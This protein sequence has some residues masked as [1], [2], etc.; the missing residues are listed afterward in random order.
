MKNPQVTHAFENTWVSSQL[1]L[2]FLT[3]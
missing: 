1:K 3:C 2:Y